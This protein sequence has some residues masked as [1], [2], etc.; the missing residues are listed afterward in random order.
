MIFRVNR[1]PWGIKLPAILLMGAKTSIQSSTLHT[2]TLADLT[3]IFRNL[4]Y[5]VFGSWKWIWYFSIHNLCRPRMIHLYLKKI[6]F[7]SCAK[8]FNFFANSVV[9]RQ[10]NLSWNASFNQFFWPL[11]VGTILV[12][13]IFRYW[14]FQCA[15][16]FY[17]LHIIIIIH[18]PWILGSKPPYF[19]TQMGYISVYLPLTLPPLY[20]SKGQLRGQ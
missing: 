8:L 16:W 19:R 10:I 5:I 15:C 17:S 11:D 18:C 12:P 14:T 4:V 1:N 13:D 7:F 9:E 2:G 20:W 3:S 6:D